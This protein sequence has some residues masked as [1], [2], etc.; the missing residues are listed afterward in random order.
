[1]T[2]A[3]DFSVTELYTVQLGTNTTTTGLSDQMTADPPVYSPEP[4]TL[5][6]LGTGMAGLGLAR[7][8]RRGKTS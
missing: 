4:G 7:A 5:A 1:M 3:G 2:S 6:I 8:R